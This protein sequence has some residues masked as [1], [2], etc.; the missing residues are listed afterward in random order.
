M[1]SSVVTLRLKLDELEMLQKL[2]TRGGACGS[3]A[4]EFFRSLLWREAI[5]RNVA[6]ENYQHPPQSVYSEMRNGRPRQETV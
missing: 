4:S 2:T 6:P 1:R 5:R 3:N